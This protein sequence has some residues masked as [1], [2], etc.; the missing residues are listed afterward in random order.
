M[1]VAPPGI[2]LVILD[3]RGK[4]VSEYIFCKGQWLANSHRVRLK[5][6]LLQ[7]CEGALEANLEGSRS[8]S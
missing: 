8:M 2:G 3:R 5:I 1:Q 6:H 7:R 4:V